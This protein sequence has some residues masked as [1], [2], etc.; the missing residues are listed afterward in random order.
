MA[1]HDTHTH[2]RYDAPGLVIGAQTL[3]ADGATHANLE[4]TTVTAHQW[5][6]A[7]S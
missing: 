4:H 7:S 5:R 2:N 3:F 6:Q 1:N